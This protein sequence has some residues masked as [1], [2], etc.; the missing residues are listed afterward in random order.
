MTGLVAPVAAMLASTV[1]ALP[2]P[3]GADQV[4]TLRQQAARLSAD[5]L[6][7]QLAVGSYQHALGV[8]TAAVAADDA[9]IAT[10]QQAISRD[11]AKVTAAR[12]TLARQVVN[13]YV[14]NNPANSGVVGALF[15]SDQRTVATRYEYQQVA[16]GDLSV[17]MAQLR[18]AETVL[19]A[20]QSALRQHQAADQATRAD[21]AHLESQAAATQQ[22]IAQQSATVT[23]QLAV[24][25][26]AQQAQQAAT[27]AAAIRA[28]QASAA[29]SSPARSTAGHTSSTTPPTTSSTAGAPASGPSQ[30]SADPA[31][32]AYLQCVVQRESHGDYTVVSS[33]GLYMGAFQF[34]QSTWN[35]AARLAGLPGLVGTPP[36]LASKAD[37]DTLAIALYAADGEQPWL[38][39]CT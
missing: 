31:L 12:R 18:T 25:V 10:T 22:T 29:P 39:D 11:D 6:Q 20:H 33:N 9:A 14:D 28:A 32:N 16:D 35:V 38:G 5:L 15:S 27:A 21:A 36:N 34:S 2:G 8:A 4:A 23:G 17:S 13:A 26:Q 1:V 24:A 30:A 37:Q 19:V 7:E 3:A